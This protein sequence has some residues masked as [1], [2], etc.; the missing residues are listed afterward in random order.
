MTEEKSKPIFF[1]EKEAKSAV[2]LGRVINTSFG[3]NNEQYDHDIKPKEGDAG[4]WG[5]AIA[6][7][8]NPLSVCSLAIALA[9]IYYKPEIGI[10]AMDFLNVCRKALFDKK[11]LELMVEAICPDLVPAVSSLVIYSDSRHPIKSEI[12]GHC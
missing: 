4:T 9:G 6:D 2:F 11:E 12:V 1:T 8:F 7:E 3:G 5:F 10:K